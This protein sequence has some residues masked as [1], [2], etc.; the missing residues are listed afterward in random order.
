[1][2]NR[3]VLIQKAQE[4]SLALSMLNIDMLCSQQGC[5]YYDYNNHGIVLFFVNPTYIARSPYMIVGLTYKMNY[6][7][8]QILVLQDDLYRFTKDREGYTSTFRQQDYV[9]YIKE[10]HNYTMHC[11]ELDCI[12]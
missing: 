8:S 1:M 7:A 2:F 6:Q 4:Y 11:Y 9:D 5:A 3:D 12:L 10:C